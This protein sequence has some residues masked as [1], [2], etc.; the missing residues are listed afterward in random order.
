[1]VTLKYFWQ[2]YYSNDIVSFS[3]H[4]E[5]EACDTDLSHYKCVDFDHLVSLV[6]ARFTT[7]KVISLYNHNYLI[8]SYFE[9]M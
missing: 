5:E 3:V 8:E 4:H 9:N 2:E 7:K 1:M 6:S